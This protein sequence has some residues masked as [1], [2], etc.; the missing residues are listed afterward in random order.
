MVNSN[1]DWLIIGIEMPTDNLHGNIHDRLLKRFDAGMIDEVERLHREGV[2]WERF[3]DLGL[4]YRYIAQYLQKNLTKEAMVAELETKIRQYA[5]RQLTWL[6]KD[7][8]IEWF[9][10]A[11][12]ETIFNRIENFLQDNPS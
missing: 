1:Y 6:K 7:R 12:T 5:K 8:E 10:A 9:S 4:E 3:D 2:T 11:D